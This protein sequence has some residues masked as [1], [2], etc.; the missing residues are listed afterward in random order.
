MPKIRTYLL[1]IEVTKHNSTEGTSLWLMQ[2]RR[3]LEDQLKLNFLGSSS[4]HPINLYSQDISK[5]KMSTEDKSL[6]VSMETSESDLEPGSST[7]DEQKIGEKPRK[8]KM[9]KDPQ[10]P[11]K[12]LSSYMLWSMDER[13]KVI[14]ELGNISVTT[15]AR[16]LGQRWKNINPEIKTRYEQL[17]KEEKEKFVNSMKD[18]NPT[19][20]FLNKVELAK[21]KTELKKIKD[22]KKINKIKKVKD[23]SAPKRPM[24]GYFLWTQ[25]NRANIIAELGNVSVPVLAKE[26]GKRWGMLDEETK[27]DYEAK[28]I[29]EK[30]KYMMAMQNYNQTQPKEQISKMMVGSVKEPVRATMSTKTSSSFTTPASM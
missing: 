12:P 19:Q 27:K 20:E 21:K 8:M 13:T 29:V 5:T 28:G 11:K 14:A 2:G 15:V 10:A 3:L 1:E 25:D 23:P 26:L 22:L 17:A 18:Y 16:E 24:S 9:P 6:S 4:K 7:R 30:E